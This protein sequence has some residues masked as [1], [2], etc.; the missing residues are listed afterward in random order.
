MINN[1]AVSIVLPVRNESGCIAE[2]LREIIDVCVR[3][4]RVTAEIIV[5]DDAS[6]DDSATIVDTIASEVNCPIKQDNTIKPFIRLIRHA[7]R[8]GQSGTLMEGFVAA[9]GEIIVSMDADGQFDPGEI[10]RLLESMDSCDMVCGIR[11]HRRDGLI[12]KSCSVIANSFRNLITGDSLTDAG[13]TYRSMRRNCVRFLLPFQGKLSGCEFFFHPLILRKAGFR[14]C[15]IDVNHR[16]RAAGESNYRLIRGRMGRGL[17][18][19]FEVRK[20][21]SW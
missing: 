1:F 11:H 7:V 15:E 10:P 8:V 12:R 14:I 21:L 6:D 17:R 4:I 9:Q 20:L 13:C 18:A 2:L 19:S 16:P 3:D 5:V